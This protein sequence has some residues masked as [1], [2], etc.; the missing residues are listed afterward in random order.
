[1]DGDEDP[2]SVRRV[3]DSAPVTLHRDSTSCETLR[4][5]RSEG[6]HKSRIY[7]LD[8]VKQPMP[9][10][11]DF[12][13][14]GTLVQPS[15]AALL[16]LEMLDRVGD[17]NTASIHARLDKRPV[18]QQT[19]RP[20]ERTAFP[21]FSISRLLADKHDLSVWRTLSKYGLGRVFP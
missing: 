15:F 14:V 17:V 5:G 19:C 7:C 4:G 9:A 18:K 1:M 13:G 20:D 8:F 10:D 11:L 3:H 2:R 12:A 6:D 16:E 21:V